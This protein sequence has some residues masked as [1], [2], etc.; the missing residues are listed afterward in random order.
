MKKI[1]TKTFGFVAAIILFVG[2]ALPVHAQFV[3][4]TYESN[5]EF[6]TAVTKDAVGNI[7]AVRSADGVHSSVIKYP[8]NS[9]TFTTIFTGLD[10]NSGDESNTGVS[11]W[12]LAVNSLGDVYVSTNFRTGNT[13]TGTNVVNGVALARYGNVIKLASNNG[14]NGTSYTA[15]VFLTGSLFFTSLAFDASNNLYVVQTDN[16]SLSHYTVRRY[17]AGSTSGTELFNDLNDD[18]ND[19]YPHG[20][21][22][23]ANGDIYVCDAGQRSSLAG[24]HKGG[25]RHYVNSGGTYSSYTNVSTNTYPMGLALDA[26][27]NLYVSETD[28][29]VY[30]NYRLNKYNASSHALIA[31]NITTPLV[32]GGN[33][34]PDGM[35]AVNSRDIYVLGGGNPSEFFELIGPATTTASGINF[36]A[37]ATTTT[38][39]NW[40]NGDGA[41]RAVFVAL[42]SSG[43]PTPVNST[44]YTANTNFGS[45]SQAG[46]GWYCVFNATTGTSVNVTGLS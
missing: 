43:T 34:L 4:K 42:A 24:G 5:N 37:T 28:G 21:A 45:G 35:A 39:I 31:G 46:A 22:V 38:T 2:I 30:S 14:Y 3:K 10:A 1:F 27:G 25:V 17:P 7:Y 19:N 6:Y 23:A 18:V 26:S 9:T 13:S 29:S 41:G 12:G 16:S 44:N 11:P 15:S 20:L 32:A 8:P 36:T 40:T 33:I